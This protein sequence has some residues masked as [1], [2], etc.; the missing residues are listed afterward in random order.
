M[1][2]FDL[3]NAA[4]TAFLDIEDAINS[5]IKPLVEFKSQQTG[6]SKIFYTYT[7]SNNI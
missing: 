3:N 5:D 2:Q 1:I 6:K 4:H 7:F